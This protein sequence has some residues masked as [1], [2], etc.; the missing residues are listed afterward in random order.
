MSRM[1][2]I[3]EQHRWLGKL[4]SSGAPSD[5]AAW[6][7]RLCY[8]VDGVLSYISEKK[9]GKAV[10]VCDL[11]NISGSFVIVFLS[12]SEPACLHV[13][14]TVFVSMRACVCLRVCEYV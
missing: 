9:A 6:R 1:T 8:C 7:E 11:V 4:N 10:K 14:V 3:F 5:A 2:H 12:E 13:C